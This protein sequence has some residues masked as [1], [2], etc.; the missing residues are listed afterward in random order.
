MA[1]H[2]HLPVNATNIYMYSFT[3]TNVEL[4]YENNKTHAVVMAVK[5]K[6]M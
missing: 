3:C 2:N 1:N 4:R 6:I 5:R